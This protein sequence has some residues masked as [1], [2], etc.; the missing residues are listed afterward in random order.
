MFSDSIAKLK[1]KLLFLSEHTVRRNRDIYDVFKGMIHLRGRASVFIGS[2]FLLA[3]TVTYAAPQYF[4]VSIV[5]GDRQFE[6][7]SAGTTVADLLAQSGVNISEYDVVSPE[8]DSFIAA[9]QTIV[10]Q[11]V[12]KVTVNAAGTTKVYLTTA[13]TVGDFLDEKGFD[14]NYYD[15]VSLP[16]ESKLKTDNELS[17]VKVIKRIERVEKAVPYETRTIRDTSMSISDSVISVNGVEGIDCKTYEVIL[18]DGVEVSRTLISAERTREP[19]DEVRIVGTQGGKVTE[20]GDN[21]SYSKVITCNATAYDLSFQ[22]CGKYPGQAGYGITATGTYAQYGTVAV[23]PRVIP[24]GTRMFIESA[25]GSF[26]YGYCVAEDTGGAIKGNK[27]DLFFN[28]N[29]ECMQFG[30]RSVKV[31]ILD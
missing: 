14:I 10:V 13:D 8:R 7:S 27:V 18:R 4:E 26:V 12:R 24:L 9:S 31:Y 2:V 17:V 25:D 21:F 15:I 28:T 11:R 3:V 6:V 23:D 22:S 5:D 30:R 1:K 20:K 19:V 16:L 29:S